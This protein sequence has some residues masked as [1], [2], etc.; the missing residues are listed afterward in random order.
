VL[1]YLGFAAPYAM[2]GL[3]PVLGRPGAFALLAVLA[4]VLA[5]SLRRRDATTTRAVNGG[6]GRSPHVG[7]GRRPANGADSLK[8]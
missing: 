7:Q 3:N 1:A 6:T 4:A 5:A 8:S 2:D